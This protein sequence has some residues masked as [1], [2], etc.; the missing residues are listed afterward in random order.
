[1]HFV[2]KGFQLNYLGFGVNE[3]PIWHVEGLFRWT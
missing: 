2:V 3:L 1:M